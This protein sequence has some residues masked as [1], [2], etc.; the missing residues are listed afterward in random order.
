MK[1]VACSDKSVQ[2]TDIYSDMKQGQW[3]FAIVMAI[4]MIAETMGMLCLR[5][6]QPAWLS[7]GLE[8][9]CLIECRI[10]NVRETAG[11]TVAR[12]SFSIGCVEFC[13]GS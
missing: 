12:L 13:Y 4:I 11:H 6:F 10:D 2:T 9:E 1:A 7:A 5:L 8:S 3:T